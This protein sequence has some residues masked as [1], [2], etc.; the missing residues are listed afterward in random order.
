MTAT[1]SVVYEKAKRAA[2]PVRNVSA[3]ERL[4]Q[5]IRVGKVYRREDMVQWS[6]SIDHDLQQLV[7]EGRLKKPAQGLYYVPRK[8][9]FGDEKPPVEEM[10]AAFLKDKNFLFFNP[11][12]YNSLRLGTTQLYN[13][14]IVYNHKRHGK[15]KLGNREFDFRVKL[16][17]PLRDKVTNEYLLVD[18]LNNLG[19]LA[20][21]DTMVLAAA[22]HKLM[23]FDV[24]KVQ[25][26]LQDYGSAATRRLMKKWLSELDATQVESV[27]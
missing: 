13:K 22:R 2:R 9:D 16:R 25:K 4:V 26:T 24:K 27:K 21:D 12:I 23:E 6:N 3:R 8:T 14:T 11:S 19:E 10:L 1:H 7:A 20:E 5:R 17:F 18:M 15:F